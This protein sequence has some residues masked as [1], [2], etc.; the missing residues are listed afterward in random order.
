MGAI[1]MRLAALEAKGRD[2]AAV[3]R[4]EARLS[5]LEAVASTGARET[6]SDAPPP[7]PPQGARSPAE[8]PPATDRASA[9][10]VPSRQT[11][12]VPAGTTA[13]AAA[14]PRAGG[15]T[16]SVPA[17]L[18]P[19]AQP[20]LEEQFGTRWV[21]W[22]GGVALA[23]GGLFLVRYSIE[24]GLIGPSVRVALGGLLAVALVGGGEWLRRQESRT[25]I[26]GLPAAHIPSILTAAGTTVA[27]ATIFA[28]YALYEFIGP[29]IAFVLL[30]HGCYGNARCRVAARPGAGGAWP[31][32]RR[33][34]AAAGGVRRTELL[35]ALCL[36]RSGDGGGVRACARSPVALA[37]D[38]GR[39]IRRVL[40]IARHCRR[41]NR[42][43]RATR[44]SCGGGFQ[45]GGAFHCRRLYLR[46]G[47]QAGSRRCHIIGSCDGLPVR[48]R[49]ARRGGRS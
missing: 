48:G 33:G 40:D 49:A 12:P 26:A 13:S 8:E 10:A 7:P 2:G 17:I 3:R 21:V 14:P 42:H 27:Y 35:G 9:A 37:C 19:L 41:P 23:L 45:P 25:G 39:G 47:G 4:L 44:L 16:T 20:D 29:P 11:P 6:A 22:V 24:Q 38:Y 34:G 1:E 30:G 43:T 15:S 32:R 36:S 28:A 18:P 5:A 46:A 31:C